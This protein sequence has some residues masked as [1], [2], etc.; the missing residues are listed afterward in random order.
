MH[1]RKSL[2]LIPAFTLLFAL[3]SA[4]ANSQP[5]ATIYLIRHAEKLT[6]GR[7][8]LSQQGFLRAALLPNLFIP[9]PSSARAPLQRPEFLFATRQSRR[10]NRPFETV[11]PLSS[12]LNLPISHEIDSEN[13]SDLASLL[14]GGKFAG[15]V[16]LV[17]W[18]HGTLPGLVSALGAQPPYTWPETQFDRIWRIDYDAG[19]KVKLTDLPQGL[20]PG[21]SK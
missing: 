1:P 9:Q 19:G 3:C 5:P 18:H 11:Q 8:D 4:S 2:L 6:D 20:L 13:I 21:D 14:L 12:A 16:V 15:R 10:S 7:E 17:S